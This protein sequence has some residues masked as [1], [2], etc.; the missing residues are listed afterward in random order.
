[1]VQPAWSVG[2]VVT[3]PPATS[4]RQLPDRPLE[5]RALPNLKRVEQDI[6]VEVTTRS[7]VIKRIGTD[8]RDHGA[9]RLADESLQA[10][11]R[12]R[13]APDELLVLRPSHDWPRRRRY[14]ARADYHISLV[15]LAQE[16]STLKDHGIELDEDGL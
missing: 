16:G 3:V 4:R 1:V 15:E 8:R 9:V 14:C 10:R 13:T 7:A 11:F 6:L 2:L 5:R 12:N